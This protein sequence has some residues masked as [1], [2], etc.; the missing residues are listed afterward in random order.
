L[1]FVFDVVIF[2]VFNLNTKADAMFS[3]KLK[4]S[5]WMIFFAFVVCTATTSI[6]GPKFGYNLCIKSSIGIVLFVILC[7]GTLLL[8][9]V[10]GYGLFKLSQ[11]RKN[12]YQKGQ[13]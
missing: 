9:K 12:K 4:L 1:M 3:E 13:Q 2:R 8:L 11:K 5:E 10:A 7:F 6:L